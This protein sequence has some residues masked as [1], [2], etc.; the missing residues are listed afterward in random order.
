LGFTAKYSQ[1]HYGREERFHAVI[2]VFCSGFITNLKGCER[3]YFFVMMLAVA[4]DE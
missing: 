1:Q 3:P 4:L 2:N